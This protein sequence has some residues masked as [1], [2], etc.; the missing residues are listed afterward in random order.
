MSFFEESL[1]SYEGYRFLITKGP[2]KE[3]LKQYLRLLQEYNV[4]IVIRVCEPSY[5]TNLLAERGIIVHDWDFP[6]GAGP[7]KSILTKWLKLLHEIFGTPEAHKKSAAK[8]ATAPQT[9]KTIALHCVAGLGRAPI[10]V[11]IALIQLGFSPLKAVEFVRS[12]RKGAFNSKQLKY[13]LKYK[14]QKMKK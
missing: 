13:V 12:K 6:D 8:G 14:K 10:L 11:A 7:P 4:G 1:I 2:L 9:P 3:N 5:P